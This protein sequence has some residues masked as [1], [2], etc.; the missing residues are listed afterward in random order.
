MV[1]LVRQI[2]D[3]VFEVGELQRTPNL[4][5]GVGVKGIKVHAEG[6]GEQHRVL[7]ERATDVTHH[8]TVQ[9]Q[10]RVIKY[11]LFYIGYGLQLLQTVYVME[12]RA[13]FLLLLLSYL[14]NDCN[15]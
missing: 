10:T 15:A 14:R 2:R 12:A 6:A 4:F 13:Q 5:V 1:E 11:G 7:R 3:K 8:R 9:I